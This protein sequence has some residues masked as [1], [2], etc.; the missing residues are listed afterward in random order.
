[1]KFNLEM[2]K[3]KEKVVKITSPLP[4]FYKRVVFT[5]QSTS[6]TVRAFFILQHMTQVASPIVL[7]I[8]QLVSFLLQHTPL[9]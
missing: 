2:F 6:V 4:L 5:V 1:M 9:Q 7:T 8:L 3:K